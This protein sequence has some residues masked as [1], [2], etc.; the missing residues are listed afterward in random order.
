MKKIDETFKIDG[1]IIRVVV[2]RPDNKPVD[3]SKL[4]TPVLKENTN[5]VDIQR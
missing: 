5:V 2:T 4:G 3:L 1:K